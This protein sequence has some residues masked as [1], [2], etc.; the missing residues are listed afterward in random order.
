M[1]AIAK[2]GAIL[3][4]LPFF[5]KAQYTVKNHL[6]LFSKKNTPVTSIA[7][8]EK[9]YV[10][11]GSKEG[12]VRFDGKNVKLFNQQNG[13]PAEKI[14]SIYCY[15]SNEIYFGTDQGK[16]FILRNETTVD[17]LKI[18]LNAEAS[19]EKITGFYKNNDKL[20]V[21]TY[22]NG[23][24]IFDGGKQSSNLNTKTGLSDDVVYTMKLIEN[25]LWCGTDAGISIIDPANSSA[26]A[27]IASSEQGL[28]DK[29]VRSI[30]FYS[31]KK[32][33]IGMQDS[34]VCFF[35]IAKNKFERFEFFSGWDKGAVINCCVSSNADLVLAAEKQGIII[36]RNSR[37]YSDE[38]NSSLKDVTLSSM[39][40]DRFNSIWLTSS[41]GV[42]QVVE[43]RFEFINAQKGLPDDKIL[44]VITDRDR[45]I[46][47]G[48]SHG[49]IRIDRNETNTYSFTEPKDFPKSTVSCAVMDD[50]GV[51]YFG[52]YENGIVVV[53]GN[54]ISHFSTKNSALS[55]D[56][57]SNLILKDGKLYVSTLGGG[58]II[59]EVSEDKL[60]LEKNYTEQDG[61]KSD[62]VY[63]AL[64]NGNDLYVA[65]DGGGIAKLENG[66]FV[67]ISDKMGMKSSTIYSMIKD[68]KGNIW[69]VTNVDGVVK[70]E[71]NKVT[72]FGTKKG[73]RDEQPAQIIEYNDVIYLFHA[74]GMDKIDVKTSQ[75]SYYD[76]LEGDL[77]PSLNSVFISN[78]I[79]YS[80]TG[81]GV[82]VYRLKQVNSDTLKPSA[83]INNFL[84][85]YKPFGT[86]SIHD[87]QHNQNNL[88]FEFGG[89]WTKNPDKL[90]FRYKLKGHEED[91]KTSMIPQTVNYNNL[92]AGDYTFI[93]QV[94]NDDD[95][96]SD[97]AEFSFSIALPIWRRPWFWVLSV[98]VVGGI[99]FYYIRWR[100]LALKK[101]NL[102]LEQKVAERTKEIEQQAEIIAA[103]NKD[104]EQLS[105]VAS[106]TDNVVLI[107][108]PNGDIEYVNE[109]FE[110]LNRITLKEMLQQKIN[111][112]TTSN[113]PQ[114]KQFVDEAVFHKRSIKYESL[115]E[116]DQTN[117][118]WEAS[119]LT[120]IFGEDGQLR[121]IIIIDSDITQSKSQQAIIEQKNK[122]IMDSIEYA[123]K[124]QTAILPPG[125]KIRKALPDSF[126]FY[127]TKDIVSG[128]FY[129]FAEAKDFCII[130]AVDCTGHGVPG[131]FMSLIGYNIL[132]KIVNENKVD[133]PAMI[134]KNLNQGVLD[135]LHSNRDDSGADGMDAAICKV[136]FNENKIE[137]AGAMRPLWIVKGEEVTEIKADKI[138]IGTKQDPERPPIKYTTHVV[139]PNKDEVFYIF[140]DGYVDQFGGVK[141][142][143]LGSSRFKELL[144]KIHKEN[145]MEQENILWKEHQDWKL[146][147]EQVDDMCVIGFRKN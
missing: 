6:N 95:V 109:A 128:D 53:S 16:V 105:L 18:S 74:K 50:N 90:Q 75:V 8:D 24:F 71:G 10:W 35:D 78:D 96:W 70:I 133:D 129:W 68:S 55:N 56:N 48:T 54:K 69:A 7:Q 86:D 11:L 84:I 87:L 98:I 20:F 58:V 51:I 27:A 67:N 140:T 13:I 29:I 113:N 82:L 63:S 104:L 28:P 17:S 83:L 126:V 46:W 40:I 59:C 5:I 107:L 125:A 115:N 12:L 14:T 91:W 66:K 2:F 34:G 146:D 137:Y 114:I 1:K 37:I 94:K 141:C 138:P 88:S 81:N 49:I 110:R 79:L 73:L 135:A 62:Y 134:L 121:K 80:A 119:T 44:S 97:P 127:R 33:L 101:E 92:D 122:D 76:V 132:N 85:N 120:P 65:A 102:I 130:A 31:D 99:I 116:K 15:K 26:K 57:I 103:A 144:L 77:E 52:T 123:R 117:K 60:T 100:T 32:L 89:V 9:G 111:I 22:G 147:N 143:K 19:G 36:F 21:A 61:L 23:V 3:F 108:K 25:K 142:K 131:A 4:L 106:R 136:Y 124:I 45:G 64:I 72:S 118:V 39:F 145:F 42:H 38:F 43:K 41:T 30:S 93:V 112:F 47:A 139:T